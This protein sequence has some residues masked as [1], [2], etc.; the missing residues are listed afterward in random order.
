MVPLRISVL[1]AWGSFPPTG[2]FEGTFGD[3][4]SYHGCLE[5]PENLDI[6]HAHYCT[7]TYRP[8]M[9]KRKDYELLVRGE[10]DDL[11]S[12]FD[13]HNSNRTDAFST[14]LSFAQYYHYVYYKYGTCFPIQCTPFDVQLVAKYIGSQ[15][16]LSM[17][18][19]KC[20]SRRKS[21]YQ[22]VIE[23][24]SSHGLQISI[25]KDLNG[26]VYIWK[27]HVTEGQFYSLITLGAFALVL[28]SFTLIDLIV[29]Q[30]PRILQLLRHHSDVQEGR[31]NISMTTINGNGRNTRILNGTSTKNGFLNITEASES[32][33]MLS[34]GLDSIEKPQKPA[35]KNLL[36]SIVDDCSIVQNFS[37]FISGESELNHDPDREISCIHGIRCITMSWI[38]VTHTMQYNDW[39]A[40]AR[41]RLVEEHLKSLITQPLFNG[42]YLVDT[43][44][45][46]SGLLTSYTS[47][48]RS[49][50][51]RNSLAEGRNERDLDDIKKRFSIKSYLIGR[52]L[53]LTPQVLFTSLLFIVLPLATKSGG[54]HWYTM[55]GEYSEYCTD[56]W[57]INML[58]IQAFYKPNEMCNFVSWWISVDMFYHL[59]AL[60]LILVA[61]NGGRKWASRSC[62][63]VV[64]VNVGLQFRRH[65]QLELPPN[66]LSTIPQAGAMW[67]KMTVEFFW[68]PVAHAFPFFWGLIVGYCMAQEGQKISG[69]LAR[70][71]RVFIGWHLVIALLLLQSY[72]T[73]FWVVGRWHYNPL[74]SASFYLMSSI[75]WSLGISWII[76][77]CKYGYGSWINELLSCRL[78]VMLSRTSY[79][80][81]LSHFLVLFTFFGS[82][83]VLLE[84]SHLVMTYI[85]IGNIIMSML[86]GSILCVFFE[87]PS[88]NLSR[89]LMKFIR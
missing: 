45:L 71:R 72:S 80:V 46:I 62:L 21:D 13:N 43:F 32:L 29:N 63:I 54:P 39:S 23:A 11:V 41:T 51:R 19:V 49:T 68:S 67:T 85:V 50:R 66:L 6:G 47:F 73:Y 56:N 53:R 20:F 57:W 35:Q 42:S 69:W 30:V 44:F 65:Y 12:M 58:H 77:A 52:Y 81:Y 17:G 26:G 55:T 83:S 7:V 76:A 22:T 75:N 31:A 84:P 61:L 33:K 28:L 64:L 70:G 25:T 89:R 74:V 5:V 24:N 15:A 34:N 1:S 3:I 60:A 48:Q 2:L 10:P 88:L 9:P 8:I 37:R 4:G 14:L 36:M 87:M 86:L 27:P 78:F 38:I 59:F 18:P 79:L 82:Q 40:F 16:I